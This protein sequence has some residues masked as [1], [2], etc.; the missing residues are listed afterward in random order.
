MLF[1]SMVVQ[2]I[3]FE[4]SLNSSS[5]GLKRGVLGEGF[6]DENLTVV[7]HERFCCTASNSSISKEEKWVQR[8]GALVGNGRSWLAHLLG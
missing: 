1:R 5:G 4:I 3:C 8:S 6:M 7:L 2:Q